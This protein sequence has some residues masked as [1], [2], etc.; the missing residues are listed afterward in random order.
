[1]DTPT[2]PSIISARSTRLPRSHGGH[3]ADDDA[4]DHPDHGG[5]KDQREGDRHR[6]QH[7]G[8]DLLAAVHEGGEIL[9]DEEVLHHQRILHRQGRSRP[10]LWRTAASVCGRGAA[11]GDARGGVGAGRGEED[12]EHQDADARTARRA[13]AQSGGGG[14]DHR[15][16]PLQLG[17]R[18]ERLAHAVAEQVERDNGDHDGNAGRDGHHRAGVEQAFAIVD[19]RAPAGRSGGC[20]PMDRNESADFGQHVERHHQRHE[21]DEGGHDIGQ[22]Y[23][24]AGCAS[25]ARP[26]A[27]GEHELAL[28]EG[29]HLAAYR[30]RDIGDIDDADDD[31]R[32][33]AGC[34]EVM[35]IGPSCRP[36]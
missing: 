32:Q 34:S 16:R 19:D 11:A 6:L 12:Q 10:K 27:R 14:R 24:G 2:R 22:R 28:R 20:T 26:G 36:W 29:E 21:D 4:E 23:R 18:I 15:L 1:M 33:R 13:F 9:R 17:A 35:V 8:D 5:A 3:D 7:C 30:A 31:D 25:A